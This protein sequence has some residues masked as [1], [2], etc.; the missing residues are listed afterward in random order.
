MIVSRI[1]DGDDMTELKY[2]EDSYKFQDNA[3]VVEFNNQAEEASIVLDQTIFYPQG[4]GQPAD[5]GI[6]KG[7]DFLFEVTSVRYYDFDDGKVYHYGRLVQGE[8][9]EGSK[10]SLEVNSE[11]RLRNA[12]LHTAGHLIDIAVRQLNLKIEATK[13][14]HF[15]E[16]SY[17]EY[18]GE[19]TNPTDYLKPLEK[20][21][22]DLISQEIS[23][24]AKLLQAEEALSMGI[25]APASSKPV[26]FVYFDGFKEAGCGCGGTH[27]KS[28]SEI[29][30]ITIRK[31]KS[32]K[33]VVR[34]SYQ[35]GRL[36]S[37]LISNLQ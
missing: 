32:K 21:C 31:I 27:L 23:V 29:D 16:G 8:I 33:G 4:G 26:R 12:K 22:N 24:I 25:T 17:V 15:P 7:D 35:V 6:I 9:T 13:G 14:Y 1:I 3:K 28:T 2:L 11:N 34:V 5:I 36:G 18:A 20:A 10:V 37:Y 19:L 30:K